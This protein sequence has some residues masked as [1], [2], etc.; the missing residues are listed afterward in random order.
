[1]KVSRFIPTIPAHKL[2]KKLSGTFQSVMKKRDC[3]KLELTSLR[4][5]GDKFN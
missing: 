2:F 4:H 1:M 5:D 3:E